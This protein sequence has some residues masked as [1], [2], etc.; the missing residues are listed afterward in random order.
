MAPAIASLVSDR[1]ELL[2]LTRASTPG[3]LVK[4]YRDPPRG[5]PGEGPTPFRRMLR[6]IV[7]VTRVTVPWKL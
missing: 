2:M 4:L 7:S 3:V 6:E 5:L 1:M